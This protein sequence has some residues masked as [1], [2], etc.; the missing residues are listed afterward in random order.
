MWYAHE[1]QERKPNTSP[2]NTDW[3]VRDRDSKATIAYLESR[4]LDSKLALWNGWYQS[5]TAGDYCL[6]VV[7]PA[8]T[9][10]IGHVYWQARDI[11]G[12]SWLRYQSPNGPRHEAFVA[13]LPKHKPVGVVIVEGPM[14]A[15]AAAGAG[16]LGLAMMGMV[17]SLATIAHVSLFLAIKEYDT[18]PVLVIMD[19]GEAANSTRIATR[20]A[21]DGITAKVAEL[22]AKDLAACHPKTRQQFLKRELSS[23][24]KRKS[25]PK[26]RSKGQRV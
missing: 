26:P 12:R 20:L 9:H 5:C 7:I 15:L 18:L 19:R 16:Y 21:S 11:T 13:V 1:Q 25:S 23:L 14:D 10:V 22:P 17:P 4:N 6:R 8:V 3:P 24:S 2:M